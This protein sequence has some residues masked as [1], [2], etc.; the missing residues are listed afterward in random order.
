[1]YILD[2]RG[3]KAYLWDIITALKNEHKSIMDE[4]TNDIDAIR[5]GNSILVKMLN[6]FGKREVLNEEII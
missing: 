6:L 1:M 2:K 5:E 3:Q 4:E